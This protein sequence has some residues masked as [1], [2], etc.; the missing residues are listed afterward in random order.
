M[1]RIIVVLAVVLSGTTMLFAGSSRSIG[2]NVGGTGDILY[3]LNTSKKNMMDFWVG[4]PLYKGIHVGATYLWVDPGKAKFHWNG[5]GEW[6]WYVGAGAALGDYSFKNGHFMIGAVPQ[7]GVEY[8]FK[9]P[10]E[11]AIDYRPTIGG[12]CGD[13]GGFYKE[14][15][16]GVYL[17][18][19]YRFN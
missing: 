18:I 11:L 8:K 14:G 3:Q 17:G 13:G 1:K 7:I 6:H 2:I 16:Y 19:H 4:F 12:L 5:K 10:L 9:F 15:L